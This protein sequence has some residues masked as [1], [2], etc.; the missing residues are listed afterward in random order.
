MPFRDAHHV[1]GVLVGKCVKEGRALT[2]LTL[3][4]LR[5]AHS[6]FDTDVY[7]AISL[8]ACVNRRSL[9]GGP[10]PVSVRQSIDRAQSWLKRRRAGERI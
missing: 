9:R 5:Q 10:A 3:N 7:E 4:E 8:E 1:S 2:D 6:A